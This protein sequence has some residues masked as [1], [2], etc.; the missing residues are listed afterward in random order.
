MRLRIRKGAVW[1]LSSSMTPASA[2]AVGSVRVTPQVE[3][4]D[5]GKRLAAPL[6]VRVLRLEGGGGL[7]ELQGDPRE[8]ISEKA[9][10]AA[11]RV[12][13]RGQW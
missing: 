10:M 3:I 5:M 11:D 2:P 9:R 4:V 8:A 13:V 1:Q 7:P 12:R 6:S